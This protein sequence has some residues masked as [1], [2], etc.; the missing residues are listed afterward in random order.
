MKHLDIALERA[1]EVVAGSDRAL[2]RFAGVIPLMRV[3]DNRLM[4]L[5]ARSQLLDSM[6]AA[7]TLG[8]LVRFQETTSALLG[9]ALAIVDHLQPVNEMLIVELSL[10]IL[11]RHQAL[12]NALAKKV[13]QGISATRGL[14]SYQVRVLAAL[15]IG[16]AGLAAAFV[17]DLD[18]ASV[19]FN[20]SERAIALRWSAAVQQLTA[21]EA[22]LRGLL[23]MHLAS[24]DR[25]LGRIARGRESAYAPFDFLDLQGAALAVLIGVPPLALQEPE[26]ARL[27]GWIDLPRE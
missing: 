1:R 4:V 6:A 19:G 16:D 27:C 22:S 25:E 18:A 9:Q 7:L 23:R 13:L 8:D 17:K 12:A 2:A 11:G 15:Q 3:F 5:A 10:A 14:E 21:A 20:A 24:V 26:A